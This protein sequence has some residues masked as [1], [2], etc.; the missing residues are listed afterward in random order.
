MANKETVYWR[1]IQFRAIRCPARHRQRRATGMLE[2]VHSEHNHEM[3]LD[4]RK[5]G[6]LKE[7]MSQRVM[8]QCTARAT[9]VSM[10]EKNETEPAK[11]TLK[12]GEHKHAIVTE[13]RKRGARTQLI[14]DIYVEYL[15]TP[16]GGLQLSIDNFRFARD[17]IQQNVVTYRCVHYK[18]L[19]CT[20]RAKTY[21]P[22]KKLQ[23]LQHKHNHP[24]YM[25]RRRN[26][27]LRTLLDAHKTVPTLKAPTRPATSRGKREL[28]KASEP[29]GYNRRGNLV[30][31][32]YCYSKASINGVANIIYWRCTEY[33]KQRCRSTL[34]TMGKDL[35]IIDT[36]HNHVPRNYGPIMPA[37]LPIFNARLSFEVDIANELTRKL[38]DVTLFKTSRI[39]MEK[40]K[41]KTASSSLLQQH[42]SQ[43]VLSGKKS[44]LPPVQVVRPDVNTVKTLNNVRPNP[45][46]IVKQL[47][48][49][50]TLMKLVKP[51]VRG[52]C[53]SCIRKINDPE[54]KK[55]LDKIITYCSACPASE[56]S[57]VNCF[58]ESHGVKT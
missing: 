37:A 42:P 53:V 19:G 12:T 52:F 31:Q 49:G 11:V 54:Y 33:R 21:G 40:T 46:H 44:N 16:R 15:V 18:P 13:R 35:Y 23:I 29:Y 2:L 25:N 57:C 28:E 17:R 38:P 47:S 48:N 6:T 1:C 27:A 51:R 5:R 7:L 22:E 32:S 50:H 43:A 41:A 14:N 55:K 56:W 39:K 34:K 4:R 24:A 58:D 26:G 20:A 9:S 45:D 8:R 36:K 10:T 30:Y 3:I